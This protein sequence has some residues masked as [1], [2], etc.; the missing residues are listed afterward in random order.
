MAPEAG[1]LGCALSHAKVWRK[2]LESDNQFA[3]VFEDD[4]VFNVRELSAAV[5]AAVRRKNLW[6]VVSF[7]LNHHG[8]P[9]KIS[10]LSVG[11]SLVV[12]LTNVQHA[13]CY[14][15]NRRTAREFLN[16]FYPIK[17]PLDHYFTASWEFDISFCGVEPRIV[18]QRSCRSQ[19]KIS[20]SKKIR[21]PAVLL[22]NAIYH[23]KR[24]AIHTIYNLYQLLLS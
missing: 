20:D 19:I 23:I 10:A 21:S 24:S 13:G 16:R 3:L 6:D 17:M 5:T 12:Y 11:E 2:F 7:E 9:R 22:P 18:R 8:N 1:T 4:V 15:V 14:L